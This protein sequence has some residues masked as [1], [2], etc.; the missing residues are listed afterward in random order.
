[1][2]KATVERFLAPPPPPA[3]VTLTLTEAE[4]Q[5]LRDVCANIAGSG[6]GRDRTDSI[7]DA[8]GSVGFRSTGKG[9]FTGQFRRDE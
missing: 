2:A 6:T 9:G 7:Y 1:M 4:A 3:I 5:T 8:L